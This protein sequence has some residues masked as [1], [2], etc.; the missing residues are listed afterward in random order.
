MDEST[1]SSSP[2][3]RELFHNSVRL[4]SMIWKE[5]KANLL[6]IVLVFSAAAATPSLESGARALL[7][8]E[9][10]H[11][12]GMGYLSSS[13]VWYLL[14]A[15]AASILPDIF[16]TI[17]LYLS[18]IFY[19]YLE[20]KFELDI[21]K[22]KADI[23]IAVHENPKSNDLFNS[24]AENGNWR[25]R[26]FFN[27]QFYIFQNL[28]EVGF[29]S[30][31]ILYSQWWVFLIVLAG[32][33]PELLVGIRYGKQVWGI[34]SSQAEVRRKYWLLQSYFWMPTL[35]ELK[36]FQIIPNF[37]S[38]IQTLFEGF[39]KEQQK[40]QKEKLRYQLISRLC[41]QAAIAFA[42]IWFVIEVVKGNFSIGALTFVLASIANLRGSLSG[43][44][45]NL[46]EQYED[47]LFLTDIF[48][49]LDIQPVLPRPKNGIVLDPEK[50][51][52]VE[53]EHV[54][55][56][57]PGTTALVLKNI[58][59]KIH[60]GEKLAVVGVN[61]AG[62]TTFV[63]L[64]CRFYDPTEGR[65]LIDGHDLREIDLQSWYRKLG[66]I[67]Q[68]Y[69]KYHFAVKDAIAVGRI[70]QPL[71]M[72]KVKEAA[73][74]S[75]SD[76]FIEEWEQSYDQMLGNEF[77]GG[78]QP[79]GGQWQK[80]AL[81]KAFYRNPNMYILDEPTSSIDA[82]AEVKIF[83]K[84]ETLPKDRSVILISHRFSTVR[85]AEKIAVIENGEISE[86]GSHEHLLELKGTYAKLFHLQAKG[87]K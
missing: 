4:S 23:D 29:A 72:E 59:L 27:R 43:L 42:T 44:F 10:I 86:Y 61:G 80:L 79:S 56:A 54:S 31:V 50:T 34:N 5:K 22:K 26:S 58:S 9:L 16:F 39:R 38:Q 33:I 85:K 87:Y 60:A 62:K 18:K 13:L 71:S 53:F 28:L 1:T 67:F 8:N 40:S 70:D 37:I 6:A 84:L 15:V 69:G 64:L 2:A 17:Q 78:V 46:A 74:M 24:V 82:D 41:S 32:T 83:E 3:V 30:M 51:S 12:V 47:S 7:I 25:M 66:V 20:S 36:I 21:L 14:L 48:K 57:Y 35:F 52:E 55:F 76:S 73:K 68:E 49:M 75:G 63:K 77:T 65:I 45:S 11:S 81:A 19:F